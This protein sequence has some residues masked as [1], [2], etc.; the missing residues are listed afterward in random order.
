[1]DGA[2]Y[3]PGAR[4]GRDV[5]A[6]AVLGTGLANCICLMRTGEGIQEGNARGL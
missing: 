1:M 2:S 3:Y 4:L 5:G 6:G